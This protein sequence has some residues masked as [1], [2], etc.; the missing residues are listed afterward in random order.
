MSKNAL[1]RSKSAPKLHQKLETPPKLLQSD[2]AL[3]KLLLRR[4]P[5]YKAKWA[6]NLLGN[7]RRK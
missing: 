2:P 1:R 5:T 4:S 6:H 3:S 7:E